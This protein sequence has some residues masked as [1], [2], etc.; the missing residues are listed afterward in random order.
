[1]FY[2][3]TYHTFEGF[4]VDGEGVTTMSTKPKSITVERK[5][6]RDAKYPRVTVRTGNGYRPTGY[7]K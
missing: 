7:T 3:Y 4:V 6:A 2:N 1:M 5:I